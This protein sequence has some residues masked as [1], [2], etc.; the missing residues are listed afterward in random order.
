MVDATD[1]F[2]PETGLTV[3]MTRSLDGAAFAAATGTVTEI[4]TGHY[5]VV[6]SA[7]DM[8]GDVV[9]HRFTATGAADFTQVIQTT[10]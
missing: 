2:T 10:A 3:T 7:A 5:K 8:N 9:T 1:G 6:A 4:S